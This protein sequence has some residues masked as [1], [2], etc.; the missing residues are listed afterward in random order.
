MTNLQLESVQM[1]SERKKTVKNI[2]KVD[3]N[4]VPM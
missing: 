4:I 2:F 3:F 1:N